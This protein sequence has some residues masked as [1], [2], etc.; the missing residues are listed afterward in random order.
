[1]LSSKLCKCIKKVQKGSRLT[2]PGAITVCNKSI[3]TNRNLKHY[4]FTCKKK[5]NR[6]KNEQFLS[7]KKLTNG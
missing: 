7:G 5:Y 6:L 3:F 2:E 4:R 1:M